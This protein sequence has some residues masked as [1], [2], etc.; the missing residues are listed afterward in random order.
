MSI[1]HIDVEKKINGLESWRLIGIYGEPNRNQKRKTWELFRH[2]ARDFNL[3][4]CAICDMN[5]IVSQNDKVGGA[6]YPTWLIEG[7]ND[8]LVASGLIDMEL[9]GHKYT[10]ERGRNTEVGWKRG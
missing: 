1:N 3:P 10:W 8:A 2:F 7:F 6:M 9:I 4:W 5:N